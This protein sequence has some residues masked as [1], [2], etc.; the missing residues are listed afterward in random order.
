MEFIESPPFTRHLSS[1]LNDE[2]YKPLQNKLARNPEVGDLMPGAQAASER[3]A[4]PT[5]DAAKDV[6]AACE[7][8]ITI[9]RETT[10][11]G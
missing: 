7:L 11:F 3:C 10:K 6:A 4:G 8:S 2:G 1:Y 9:S 5:P